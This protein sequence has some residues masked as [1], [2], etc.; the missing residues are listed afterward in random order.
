S[1]DPWCHPVNLATGPEGALYIVDFYRQW[2]EHPQFVPEAMRKEIDWRKGWRHGRIWRLRRRDAKPAAPVRLASAGAAELV[3]TLGDGNGWRRDT[4]QRLLV[5][6]QDR[7]AVP[8]LKAVVA[9]PRSALAQV[10]ALWTLEGLGALD[11][12]T[13]LRAFK[14]EQADV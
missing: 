5:E 7:S 6:R 4:A 8:L 3:R 11:D 12:E 10:H 1:T 13:L 2:V 14:T 9:K